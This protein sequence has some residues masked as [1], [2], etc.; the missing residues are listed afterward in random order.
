MVIGFVSGDALYT[1]AGSEAAGRS[2][3]FAQNNAMSSV[4]PSDGG[5]R[6]ENIRKS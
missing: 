6:L 2:G 5:Y 1:V 4:I 3:A